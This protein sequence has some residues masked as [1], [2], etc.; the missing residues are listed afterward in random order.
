VTYL[1]VR[2]KHEHP[3]EP[4]VLYSELD[5]A[6]MERRKID[7][8]PDGRWR[9]ADGHEEVGGTTLGEAPTPSVEQLNADPAFEAEEIAGAEFEKLWEVRRS[10][11]IMT[12]FPLVN[13]NGGSN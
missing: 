8:F 6:R 5:E 4:V 7:I 9:Y 11:R 1:L 12:P 13:E 2:W 10:A 3:D